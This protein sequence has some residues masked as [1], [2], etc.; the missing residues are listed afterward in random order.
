VPATPNTWQ[1][2]RLTIAIA[3]I[4]LQTTLSKQNS[5]PR[6]LDVP[7]YIELTCRTADEPRFRFLGLSAI[8]QS[9]KFIELAGRISEPD[10]VGI[11]REIPAPFRAVSV[12]VTSNQTLP[13]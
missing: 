6:R 11:L 1:Q 9:A 2:H 12:L 4:H 5:L 7:Y 8:H 3:L 13:S 10:L